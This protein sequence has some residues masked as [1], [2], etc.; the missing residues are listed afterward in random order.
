[1]KNDQK[2][3]LVLNK[4]LFQS[5]NSMSDMT[6]TKNVDQKFTERAT[7]CYGSKI[8]NLCVALQF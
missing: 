7:H 4:K 3:V 2:L 8:V 6:A 5:K 1:M